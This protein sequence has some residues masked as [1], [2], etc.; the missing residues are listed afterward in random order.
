MYRQK[1]PHEGYSLLKKIADTKQDHFCVTSNVDGHFNRVFGEQ[2]C[3]EVHGSIHHIQCTKCG[4]IAPNTYEIDV[5]MD[6]M[7]CRNVPKC[8]KCG[9]DV[10]PNILMFNDWGWD[11]ERSGQQETLFQRFIEKATKATSK[12]AMVEVGAGTAIPTIRRMN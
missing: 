3:Y 11:S 10:R 1:Q 4:G 8:L 5:D 9:S 7:A 2:R 12:L 6:T